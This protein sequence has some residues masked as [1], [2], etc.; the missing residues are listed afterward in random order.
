MFDSI[1]IGSGPAGLTAAIYLSRAGLKNA[2]FCGPEPGG[3]LISTTEVENFPGFPDGI[4]GSELMDKI[5]I[6]AKKFGTKFISD[7]INK[8]SKSDDAFVLTTISGEKFKAK[9]III[10]T[11]SSAKYLNIEGEKENIGHGVSACAT[12]DGFFYSGKDVVVIGGGDSAM[13]EALYLT[14]FASKVTLI[15]RRDELRASKIMQKRVLE[16]EKIQV[17]LNFTPSRVLSNEKGVTGLEI[18]DNT[19]HK[20]KVIDTEGVFVA[21]GHNPNTAFLNELVEL[22]ENDYIITE[23]GTSKT[24]LAGVFA[25]GDVQDNQYRQAITS[26]G[27][28]AIAALDVERYLR[29]IA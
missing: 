28:G 4:L 6:Q 7:I 14:R 27:S 13:E 29:E 9:S 11:G 16:N 12:C 24:S 21:I 8:I 15:H 19:T 17:K 3:Q 2:L 25:S 5:E 26:A 23:G 20:K 18:I 10:S 1:I 22:D